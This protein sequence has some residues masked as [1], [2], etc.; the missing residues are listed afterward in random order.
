MAYDKMGLDEKDRKEADKV[1]KAVGV[2]G[3][4][5]AGLSVAASMAPALLV[6]GVA[7][8]GGYMVAKEKAPEKLEVAKEKASKAMGAAAD[9]GGEFA[10]GVKKGKDGK[11]DAPAS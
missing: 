6:G 1:G 5:A 7:A 11:E 3:A 4:A 10:K 8:A 9:V 2:L